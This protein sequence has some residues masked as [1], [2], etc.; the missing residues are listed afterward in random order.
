MRVL[1]GSD[2]LLTEFS[3]SILYENIAAAKGSNTPVAEFLISRGYSL[4]RYQ[5]YLQN[6]IPINSLKSYREISM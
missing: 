5:P 6:L 4:F 3:P 2:R 1:M